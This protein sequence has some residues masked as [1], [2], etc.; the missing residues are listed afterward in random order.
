MKLAQGDI[1]RIDG[2]GATA[3]VE[4]PLPHTKLFVYI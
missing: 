2:N 1:S 4:S 3:S